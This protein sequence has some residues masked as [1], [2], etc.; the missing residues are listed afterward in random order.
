MDEWRWARDPAR[1]KQTKTTRTVIQQNRESPS[2]APT[3]T[4][5]TV[6]PAGSLPGL[7]KRVLEEQR[8]FR[9]QPVGP[10]L[11]KSINMSRCRYTH[12][13]TVLRMYRQIRQHG[14]TGYPK[15]NRLLPRNVEPSRLPERRSAHVSHAGLS[16][17]VLRGPAPLLVSQDSYH[18]SEHFL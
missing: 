7:P 17:V 6:T 15:K 16:W 13:S 14:P 8:C 11:P 5:V 18:M 3:F 12:S 4:A 9:R 1:L 10:E 2:D